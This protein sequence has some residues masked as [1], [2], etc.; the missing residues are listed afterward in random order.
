VSPVRVPPLITEQ[1]FELAQA[2]LRENAHFSTRNT[3]ELS[4]L[5]G[6]LVCR[7]CGYSYYRT[8]TSTRTSN[9]RIS[10][11]RC[12]GQDGWRHPDGKRCTS[13]PIRADELDPLVWAEVRRLLEHPELVQAEIDRRLTALRAEHPAAR[14]RDATRSNETS[15]APTARPPA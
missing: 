5:Q 10:Y 8:S 7:E 14:R 11:Y 3:K 9:K 2:R 4:L 12:I 13:H 15:H 1:T 6:V